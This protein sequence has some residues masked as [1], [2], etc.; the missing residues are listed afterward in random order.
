MSDNPLDTAIDAVLA[1]LPDPDKA[2]W[3]RTQPL[4]KL[5]PLQARFVAEYLV[6]MSASNAY[7]RAAETDAPDAAA[8]AAGSRLLTHAAVRRAIAEHRDELTA[9]AN[10]AVGRT[11]NK[12][13]QM[14]EYDVR[15][16]YHDDGSPRRI[17]ELDDDSAAAVIGV[18]TVAIGNADVGVGT[19]LKYK[20]VDKVA[21]LD[22]AMKYH[23][24]FAKDNAQQPPPLAAIQINLVRPGNAS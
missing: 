17:S 6:D 24:L 20:L 13:R 15:K 16:F 10:L 4:H 22:K 21:V 23:G 5:T 9:K 18:E 3:S 2:N 11:L 7:R 1:G 12:L 14:L 8:A 19:V